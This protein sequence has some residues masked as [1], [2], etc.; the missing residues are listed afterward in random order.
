MQTI[1]LVWY[2]H[3]LKFSNSTF[4]KVKQHPNKANITRNF[5]TKKTWQN[6]SQQLY[7]ITKT[8]LINL[9]LNTHT[10]S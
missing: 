4:R 5:L 3:S 2:A 8:G 1:S 7:Q 9:G 6:A 10:Q